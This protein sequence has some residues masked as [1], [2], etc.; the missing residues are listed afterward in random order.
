VLDSSQILENIHSIQVVPQL[1][2]IFEQAPRDG[3]DDSVII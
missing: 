3:W 2:P 1:L